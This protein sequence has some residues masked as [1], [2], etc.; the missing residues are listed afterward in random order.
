MGFPN[1]LHIQAFCKGQ[2]IR[3]IEDVVLAGGR[4]TT[5]IVFESGEKLQLKMLNML[6]VR[7]VP[8]DLLFKLLGELEAEAQRELD[9]AVPKSIGRL[10]THFLW[11]NQEEIRKQPM[12][13]I[14]LAKPNF[15]E[16]LAT[17]PA[18]VPEKGGATDWTPHEPRL[19][20]PA[21]AEQ[22]FDNPDETLDAV[23]EAQRAKVV[24]PKREKGQP[25]LSF[26]LSEKVTG[27]ARI[28]QH[29]LL[30]IKADGKQ[31]GFISYQGSTGNWLIYFSRPRE[32]T[33]GDPAPF[34]NSRVTGKPGDFDSMDE[35]KAYVQENWARFCSK[36]L[37]TFEK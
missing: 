15:G 23:E 25:R 12:R 20:V 4:H 31:C 27:L 5:E 28:G 29:Q 30:Y 26:K 16:A 2:T 10:L 14:V 8:A 1:S 7:T 21:A 35:A 32:V 6:H 34:Y 18:F 11:E 37:Y 3:S 19:A 33:K 22:L 13:P 17:S 36:P 9:G 24:K